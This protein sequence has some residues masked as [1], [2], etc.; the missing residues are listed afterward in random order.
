MSDAPPSAFQL[1]AAFCSTAL[2]NG[3]RSK[4]VEESLDRFGVT[5]SSA[6]IELGLI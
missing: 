6:N 4:S 3:N 5:G 2:V 1:Q